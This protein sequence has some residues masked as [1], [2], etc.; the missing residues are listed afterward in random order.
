MTGPAFTPLICNTAGTTAN[1]E[2][3]T[4]SYPV[5][6]AAQTQTKG[7]EAALRSRS[8]GTLSGLYVRLSANTRTS[9]STWKSRINGADGAQSVSIGAAATGSFEDVTNTDTIAVGD[10]IMTAVALGAGFGSL[11]PQVHGLSFETSTGGA[12]P[13][14]GT[15]SS[16][17]GLSITTSVVY[18]MPGP[19]FMATGTEANHSI[20]PKMAVRASGLGAYIT[21]GSVSDTVTFTV[22]KNGADT[23]LAFTSLGGVTGWFENIT[24]EVTFDAE[25]DQAIAVSRNAGSAAITVPTFRV[26]YNGDVVSEGWIITGQIL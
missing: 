18:L 25:D 12:H 4:R 14:P 17:A 22:R 15:V 24:D 7:A 20:K 3:V 2:N 9:T 19:G 13:L 26:I 23:A 6:G 16:G 1:G 11:T 10:S 21:N 5:G 8:A